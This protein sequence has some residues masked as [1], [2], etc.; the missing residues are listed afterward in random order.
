MYSN[1][2]AKM[3]KT[4][5]DPLQFLQRSFDG[6]FVFLRRAGIQEPKFEHSLEYGK[7]LRCLV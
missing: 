4:I 1:Q 7:R 3:L 2:C 5:N 6:V